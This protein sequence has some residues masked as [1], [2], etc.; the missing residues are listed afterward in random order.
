M[1]NP[2]EMLG[3]AVDAL[4]LM[5]RSHGGTFGIVCDVLGKLIQDPDTWVSEFKRFARK[6]PCWVKSR[7]PFAGH[8]LADLLLVASVVLAPI[9]GLCIGET[10]SKAIWKKENS[11]RFTPDLAW[12]YLEQLRRLGVMNLDS[13]RSYYTPTMSVSDF[14]MTFGVKLPNP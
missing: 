2:M 13:E 9:E 14:E 5:Y 8:Q 4:V 6:E 11:S 7:L 10:V 1:S 3:N 12:Y